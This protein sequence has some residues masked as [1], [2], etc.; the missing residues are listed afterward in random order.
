MRKEVIADPLNYPGHTVSE[1]QLHDIWS[2]KKKR[3]FE[4]DMPKLK[5]KIM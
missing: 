5:K 1:I 3:A 2:H 4:T